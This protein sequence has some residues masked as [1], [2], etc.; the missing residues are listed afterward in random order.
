M[1]VLNAIAF[2]IQISSKDF[3]TLITV[4]NHT[5]L[6]S[7]LLALKQPALPVNPPSAVAAPATPASALHSLPSAPAL[8]A[9]PTAP[10]PANAS[11]FASNLCR[12]SIV[13]G[14]SSA[15]RKRPT[16][17]TDQS[18][19]T[20]GSTPTDSKEEK[21]KHISSKSAK[22]KPKTKLQPV[23]TPWGVK[24]RSAAIQMLAA[25]IEASVA[26][27]LLVMCFCF[28]FENDL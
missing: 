1:A 24:A 13:V 26:N 10:K 4:H 14:E 22:S 17:S 16:P 20:A 5:A 21:A 27:S 8:A 11:T 6:T 23:S 28:E 15:S 12:S 19:A 3:P 7:L 9:P 25:L 2:L 18:T